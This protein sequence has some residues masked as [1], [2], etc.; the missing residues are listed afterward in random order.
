MKSKFLQRNPEDLLSQLFAAGLIIEEIEEVA[1]A[2]Q[3]N[4]KLLLA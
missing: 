4:M 2:I 1:T 3:P